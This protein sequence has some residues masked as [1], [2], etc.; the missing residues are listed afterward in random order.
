MQKLRLLFFVF[1]CLSSTAWGQIAVRNNCIDA[2]NQI[3]PT[4]FELEPSFPSGTTFEW[5]FG[6]GAWQSSGTEQI[7]Q[8]PFA[9]TGS[10]AIRAR[11]TPPGGSPSI[12][13]YNLKIGQVNPFFLGTSAQDTLVE[14]CTGGSVTLPRNPITLASLATGSVL[15]FPNGET[16]SS[17][18][19]TKEGCYSVKKFASD[20]SGCYAEARIEVKMCG[21]YPNA[22]SDPSAAGSTSTTSSCVNC[23]QWDLGQ[24]LKLVFPNDGRFPFV[25]NGP[26]AAPAQTAYYGF[27]S[28]GANYLHGGLSSNGQVL[29]N[30][31]GDTI[32]TRLNGDPSL[33]QS[34]AIFPKSACR[35]CQSEFYV[36]TAKKDAAG[37]I[38]WYYSIVDVSKNGGRG[39]MVLPINR[40]LSSRP[41]MDRFL[42][43]QGSTGFQLIGFDADGRN[44]R[45]IIFGQQGI[46]MPQTEV[47][48]PSL[49]GSGPGTVRTSADNAWMA[50]ALPP[51]Q[52]QIFDNT[53]NPS[54]LLGSIS[55]PD[56]VY[57]VAF[58]PDRNLL[59]VT[60]KNA[61]TG[62][63]ELI[64][65]R[66]DPRNLAGSR[67]FTV[68]RAPAG[69]SFGSLEMDPVNGS[70]LYIAM[71]G[72]NAL[73]SIGKPNQVMF[74]DS[75]RRESRWLA[76][77][78]T[79][80][81]PRAY[82]LGLPSRSA[83]DQDGSGL[84]ISMECN[85]L[86]FRF[87]LS[88]DLCQ[89]R[90]NLLVRWEIY[91]ATARV[92]I[93]PFL[94]AD[95]VRVV[96]PV[97]GPPI[98][99][100]TSLAQINQ[101]SFD[102]P[103]PLESGYYVVVARIN[104][105]CVS[106]YLL[107]AQLF[108]VKL[109]RP[110]RLKAQI[111]KIFD[112][113]STNPSCRFPSYELRARTYLNA[114][115]PSPPL[116]Q[117][118]LLV[119]NSSTLRFEWS[120]GDTSRSIRIPYPG[121]AGNYRLTLSDEESGCQASQETQ[122][123]FYSNDQLPQVRTWNICM[124]EANPTRRLQVFPLALNLHYQWSTST[125]TILGLDTLNQLSVA[126]DGTYHLRLR[127]DYAC[128]LNRSYQVEDLC[129]AQV[130]APTVF[131]P[132]ADLPENR[133][134]FPSWNWSG[135]VL[136]ASTPIQGSSPTRFYTKNRTQIR[137]LRIF[138][139][140]GELIY[141][142]SLSPAEFNALDDAQIR[143]LGWD[144]SSQ[145]KL[146]P[147]DTYAWEVD[148]LSIDFPEKGTQ[149]AKGAVLVLNTLNPNAP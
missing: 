143:K 3:A 42:V 23:P 7:I 141:Q 17:I 45:K 96:N 41:A 105:T 9:R 20:G 33:S 101:I 61:A 121:G 138:N 86:N 76:L 13:T 119:P 145:G 6:D 84:Q 4:I 92:N 15:W 122:V 106:N 36:V 90:R 125:G 75:T 58:S 34:V 148:Y 55:T 149:T 70:K 2:C 43:A 134:F 118:D 19:V 39:G 103:A 108:Y 124:D 123:N 109:L 133:Y 22:P 35:G 78:S 40:L 10:F 65:Y 102:F 28:K 11:A 112:N 139:R 136:S 63:S 147:Q 24:N 140:W 68:A 37:R 131:S 83:G 95:G 16:G 12:Y 1:G 38:K 64:Q 31:Q 130:L 82:G 80:L 25:E 93:S 27:Q 85:G 137:A 8:R 113:L 89:K 50:M 56:S 107:D 135:K 146:V 114:S 52:V 120:T 74:N 117:Y 72:A 116:S 99:T 87:R 21:A 46:S 111:D 79:T 128:E 62:R 5:D 18:N 104:N 30:N 91:R 26:F 126:K 48:S 47:Q 97:L 54:R 14:I 49:S 100:A 98:H 132:L 81:A 44:I 73:A 115:N 142:R 77:D 94:N 88:Q 29:Y 67:A 57:G 59:Y 32:S 127:D 51:N 71:A 144:G 110:F 129:P 53:R 66:L 60:T 69:Q